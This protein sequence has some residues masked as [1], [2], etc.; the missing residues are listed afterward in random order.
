MRQAEPA[1]HQVSERSLR[2]RMA[3]WGGLRRLLTQPDF[4]GAVVTATV[5]VPL[6]QMSGRLQI[7]GGTVCPVLAGI[8][9]GLIGIVLAAVALLTA[10]TDREFLAFI[11]RNKGLLASLLFPYEWTLWACVA[12]LLASLV[13]WL[14]TPAQD[15]GALVGSPAANAVGFLALCWVASFT[16]V[17]A[18]LG[19]AMLIPGTINLVQQRAD[20]IVLT[21][22]AD[23]GPGDDSGATG[24]GQER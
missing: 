4:L 19:I 15:C 22:N 3:A 9:G 12:A 7:L 18:V 21:D 16:F 20:H 6:L 24:G 13:T 5:A 11:H 2:A 8:M 17:Y 23:T 10:F 1:D 14:A